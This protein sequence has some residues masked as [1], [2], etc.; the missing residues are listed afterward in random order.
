M[1]TCHN[2]NNTI[3]NLDLVTRNTGKIEVRISSLPQFN[4]K[5]TKKF[6]C[7]SKLRNKHLNNP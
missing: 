4:K 2:F 5:I 1:H 7:A 3:K 6:S